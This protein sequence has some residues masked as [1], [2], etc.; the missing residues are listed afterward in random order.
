M[1]EEPYGVNIRKY[2]MN[3][4]GKYWSIGAIYV[5]LDRLENKGFL[6][7][8]LAEPTSER[9]GKSKRLL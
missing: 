6:S 4:T 8:R 3:M 1:K 5:P 2:I 7:S 9:G